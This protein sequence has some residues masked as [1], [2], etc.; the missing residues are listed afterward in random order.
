MTNQDY[1][2]RCQAKIIHYDKEP[3]LSILT[4]NQVGSGT[5]ITRFDGEL[6]VAVDVNLRLLG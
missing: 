6:K 5:K 4:E 1:K 3:R 2:I